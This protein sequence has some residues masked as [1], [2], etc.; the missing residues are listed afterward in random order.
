VLEAL[1]WSPLLAVH[2]A[3]AQ[4][5]PDAACMEEAGAVDAA[6]LSALGHGPVDPD[7]LL[8]RLDCN[9][10]E[11][12]ARLLLLE[13]AGQLERLPGGRVQRIVGGS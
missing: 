13:L 6:L 3:A 12:S 7:A 8:A 5:R 2:A 1:A 9:A 11:L 4:A 10:G